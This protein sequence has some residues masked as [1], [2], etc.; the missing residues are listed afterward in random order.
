MKYPRTYHV[1]WSLGCS[2]DDKIH[3]DMSFF[4]GK[5]VIVTEK[6]DGENSSLYND[7]YHARSIDTDSHVSRS[8]LRQF[9]AS[10]QYDI[11]KGYRICGENMFAKHSIEYSNLDSYFYGFSMWNDRNKCLSWDETLEWFSLL[12]ITNVP[13]LYDG[14]YD[15]RKIKSLWDSSVHNSMEG[16][17]IRVADCFEYTNFI[18]NVA[19]FVRPNHVQ[20]DSHWKN[21]VIIPNKLKGD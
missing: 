18:K 4:H 2:S 8:W 3:P 1:P 11:P 10:I 13:V 17:V 16:Y 6:L 14:I 7:K 19:K 15:E 21:S 9:H 20:T 12:G 5:R